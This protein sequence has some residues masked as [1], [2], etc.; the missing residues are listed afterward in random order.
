VKTPSP[1]AFGLIDEVFYAANTTAD[2]AEL[3]AIADSITITP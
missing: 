1:S 2:M 3:Q